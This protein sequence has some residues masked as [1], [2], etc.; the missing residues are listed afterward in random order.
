MK[1]ELI[2]FD[3]DGTLLNTLDDLTDSA[4]L[5]LE[6]FN[7]PTKTLTEIRNA[8][9][10]GVEKF[11]ERIIPQG[12]E[13]PNFDELTET[14]KNFYTQNMYNKTAPYE[15]ILN[16]LIDLKDKGYYIAVASNKFDMAVKT[17]CEKYFSNLIDFSIGEN[18]KEGIKEKPNPDMLIKVCERANINIENAIYIGDSEVDIQT[19]KNSQIHCISVLWGFKDEEFLTNNGAEIIVSKPEEILDV[20]EDV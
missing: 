18:I 15:G 19:A 5:V 20:L 2:I 10:N 7:Y 9:G 17:L 4:N 8:V 3:L 1:K 14:F 6:K 13:N 12:L 16:L 11:I